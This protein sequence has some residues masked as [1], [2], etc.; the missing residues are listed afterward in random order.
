MDK[1]LYEESTLSKFPLY[2]IF[3]TDLDAVYRFVNLPFA[4]NLT[5]ASRLYLIS[6]NTTVFIS[7]MLLL[8]K[9]LSIG[10]SILFIRFIVFKLGS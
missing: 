4:S 3:L 6:S 2:L 7:G 8:L 1:P 9:I 5:P 10:S